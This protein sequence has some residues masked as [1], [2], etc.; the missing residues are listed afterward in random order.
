MT[1]FEQTG[2]HRRLAGFIAL[3]VP[4]RR[5]AS[6]VSSYHCRRCFLSATNFSQIHDWHVT[7][8]AQSSR[9]LVKITGW[10]TNQDLAR[11]DRRVA[12]GKKKIPA[13]RR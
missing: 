9:T 8:R 6:V 7:H 11:E 10:I 1:S 12:Y 2:V 5:N 3:L 4:E 13:R